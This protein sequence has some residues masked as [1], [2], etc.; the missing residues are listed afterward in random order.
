MRAWKKVGIG[1]WV[2]PYLFR[3]N[4]IQ[5]S[6][7]DL[8]DG[9]LLALSPGTDVPDADFTALDDIGTVKVLL[10]PGAFHNM[11]LPLWHARYPDAALFGPDS[12][13]THIAKQHPDLPELQSLTELRKL[14][15]PDV[16]VEES[17]G[18]KKADTMVVVTR[19][20]ATT[21]FTNEVL[22]NMAT[23]PGN[24][25]FKLAFKLTG[26]GPGL[27]IN[28]MA[29]ALIGGKKAEIRSYY[30]KLLQSHPPTRL[31]PCHG[32]VIED[33]TLVAQLQGIFER[34]L[35]WPRSSFRP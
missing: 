10:T 3:G 18:M 33:P 5:T 4:P 13:I 12:A 6:I 26:S 16:L 23:W 15:A 34:R 31:I 25:M 21:W 35:Q 22:T 2:R 24:P 20:D 27:N 7:I 17:R 9:A 29:M 30:E 19:D 32:D 8:G 28:K 11:G 1:I 14:L